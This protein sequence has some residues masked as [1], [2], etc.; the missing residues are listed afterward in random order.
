MFEIIKYFHINSGKN[1]YIIIKQ[2]RDITSE[3]LK[4]NLELENILIG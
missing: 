3:L 2:E 1:N 4:K